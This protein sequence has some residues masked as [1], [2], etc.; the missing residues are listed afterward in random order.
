LTSIVHL[1]LIGCKLHGDG[2]GTRQR[3]PLSRY[4]ARQDGAASS[5]NGLFNPRLGFGLSYENNTAAATCAAHL[6]CASTTLIGDPDQLL[7][8]RRGDLG[9][10]GL[11]ELPLLTRKRGCLIPIGVGKSLVQRA[12]DSGDLLEI[13]K[14]LFV[15]VDVG[16]EDLPIVNA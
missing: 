10:V 14:D 9:S 6:G 4:P 2:R 7:N 13:A 3:H 15:A 16:F 5:T 12:C 8:Q 11:T 1:L